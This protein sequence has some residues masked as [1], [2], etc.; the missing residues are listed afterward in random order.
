[1]D[2]AG[3]EKPEDLRRD[4]IVASGTIPDLR[5]INRHLGIEDVA[6]RLDLRFG[7]ANMVHCWHAERHQNGDRTASASIWRA[8]NKIKCFGCADAR[9]LCV[10][11]L[12]MDV[13]EVDVAGAARW[14]DA[15]FDVPQIPKGQHL[16]STPPIRAYMVGH[17]QPI[18]LLVK[19]GLWA[20]LSAQT[21]RVAPALVALA[22][23]QDHDTFDVKISYRGI[24]RYSG[25]RSE[26]SVRKALTELEE[27]GW[28]RPAP[29]EKAEGGVLR[30]V[31]EYV[32]TPYSDRLWEL[33]NATTAQ[34]RTEIQQEKELRRQQRAARKAAL[35]AASKLV[36][37]TTTNTSTS[38]PPTGK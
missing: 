8:Q 18:E 33:A 21:Q 32:L 38:P 22:T 36:S 4:S 29:R 34:M 6:R 20:R 31:G 3:N 26:N 14:L 23:R 24:M 19:S 27:I 28:L 12:V 13:L 5:W 16:D 25:V 7:G 30:E 15:N 11:D 1:M 9:P 2:V 17:E 35:A 10:V 37:G